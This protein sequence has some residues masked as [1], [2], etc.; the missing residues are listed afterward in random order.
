MNQKPAPNGG[1]PYPA[2]NYNDGAANYSDKSQMKK[3][4]ISAQT[5]EKVEAAK[6]YIESKKIPSILHLQQPI[7]ITTLLTL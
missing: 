6:S 2:P 3:D 7:M 5:K 1:N 4:L